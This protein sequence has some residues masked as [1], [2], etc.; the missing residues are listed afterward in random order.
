MA[1]PLTL[2][3]LLPPVLGLHSYF[4]LRVSSLKLAALFGKYDH[5][6]HLNNTVENFIQVALYTCYMQLT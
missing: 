2:N 6:T 5:A 4:D 3:R 1:F